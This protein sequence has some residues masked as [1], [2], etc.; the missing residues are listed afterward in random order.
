MAESFEL[1][2]LMG[3]VYTLGD[4]V[5]VRL[6]LARTS[7]AAA[8]RELLERQG[9]APGDLELTQLVH[10]DPR[11][12]YVVCATGLVAGMETLLGVGAIGLDRAPKPELLV[13]DDGLPRELTDLLRRALIGAADALVRSRAA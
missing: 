8:I 12:R 4:G 6:R 7:D 10:F 3:H 11:R 9:L 5:R 13:V 1:G 2:G